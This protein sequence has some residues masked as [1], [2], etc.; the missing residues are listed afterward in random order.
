VPLKIDD[1]AHAT[2][3]RVDEEGTEAAAANAVKIVVTG[4]QVE[5][6]MP[7]MRVDRPFLATL[8][9]RGRRAVL[10]FRRIADPQPSAGRPRRGR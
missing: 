8:R 9:N 6:K 10:F 1:V 4:G 2:F 7:E 3:L 5:P